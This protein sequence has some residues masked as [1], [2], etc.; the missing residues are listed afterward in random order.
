MHFPEYRA[1]RLRRTPVLRAM[2]REVELNVNDFILPFFV[3]PGKKLENQISSMPGH[4]QL[5]PDS[6]LKHLKEPV[7]ALRRLDK[8]PL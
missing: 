2:V 5:S 3:R 1:R 6:L 4:F 8:A 7:D